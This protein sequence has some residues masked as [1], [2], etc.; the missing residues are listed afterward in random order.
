MKAGNP[1]GQPP[2]KSQAA[3]RIRERQ[4][5]QSAEFKGDAETNPQKN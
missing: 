4:S 1:T 3:K 2:G 5:Q